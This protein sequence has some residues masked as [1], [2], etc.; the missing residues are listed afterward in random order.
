MRLMTGTLLD[1]PAQR[2]VWP[3]NPMSDV[4][5]IEHCCWPHGA[6]GSRV[7]WMIYRD[8]W[9]PNRDGGWMWRGVLEGLGMRLVWQH[10]PKAY[11]HL[12]TA[13]ILYCIVSA[14]H[15]YR[16]ESVEDVEDCGLRG[17]G[18]SDVYDLSRCLSC[19]SQPHHLR[20]SEYLP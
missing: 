4:I 20:V 9:L 14:T 8:L 7:R 1:F 19:H 3:G 11:N 10:V 13:S 2:T 5:R 18:R 17:G 15:L 16:I 6:Y 12:C